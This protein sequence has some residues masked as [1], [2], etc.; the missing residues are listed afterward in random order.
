MHP[1]DD[2][3]NFERF[4]L[5]LILP[6]TYVPPPVQARAEVVGVA[7]NHAMDH[8]VGFDLQVQHDDPFPDT[9]RLDSCPVLFDQ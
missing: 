2:A 1:D 9:P 3:D 5:W 8:A 7:S 4:M 6:V